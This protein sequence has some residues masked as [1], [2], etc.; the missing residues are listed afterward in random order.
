M[1]LLLH[2]L[3]AKL[4]STR[5]AHHPAKP[6]AAPSAWQTSRAPYGD[7]APQAPHVTGMRPGPPRGSGFE[8]QCNPV[9]CWEQTSRQAFSLLGS[10]Q[11]HAHTEVEGQPQRAIR[12]VRHALSHSLR[13]KALARDGPS[14]GKGEDLPIASCS[15]CGFNPRCE[16]YPP[17]AVCS[18][19]GCLAADVGAVREYWTSLRNKAWAAPTPLRA[20]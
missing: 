11:G 13:M 17:R 8:W 20:G 7:E 1:G 16:M 4:G 18:V 5:V 15:P 6:P 2:G 3:Q 10:T 14:Q 12:W 9:L 19:L